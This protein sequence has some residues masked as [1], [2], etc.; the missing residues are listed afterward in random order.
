MRNLQFTYMEQMKLVCMKHYSKYMT[1]G[2]TK[3]LRSYP[4][5]PQLLGCKNIT[6]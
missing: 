5:N 4:A 3:H 6:F 1:A 2:G